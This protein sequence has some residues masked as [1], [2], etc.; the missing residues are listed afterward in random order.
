MEEYDMMIA[1]NSL[2]EKWF[3]DFNEKHLLFNNGKV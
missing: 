2:K 1:A 3:M